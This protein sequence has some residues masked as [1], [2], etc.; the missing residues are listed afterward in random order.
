MAYV[1]RS[2]D[3]SDAGIASR[4][5]SVTSA[6]LEVTHWHAALTEATL[7]RICLR[8]PRGWTTCVIP[9]P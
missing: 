5:T 7:A 8:D 6:R 9:P 4:S 2:T 1:E 3:V